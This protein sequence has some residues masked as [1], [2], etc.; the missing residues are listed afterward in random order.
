[1]LYL[2]ASSDASEMKKPQPSLE[3][4]SVYRWLNL[5]RQTHTETMS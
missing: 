1:M 3:G 4:A 2:S 5:F